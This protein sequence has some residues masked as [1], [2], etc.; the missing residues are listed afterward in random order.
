MN[1]IL[2]QNHYEF[3][4]ITQKASR[5]EIQKA[6]QGM[7]ETFGEKS[8]AFY[9]LFDPEDVSLIQ[10]R[11]E[12]AYT[13]LR[14]ENLRSA[15]DLT[16]P[17]STNPD[18]FEESSSP[19][20]DSRINTKFSNGKAGVLDSD[21]KAFLENVEE[22][23]TGKLLK[24]YREWKGIKLEDLERETR[25]KFTY[26]QFIEDDHISK[27]PNQVYLRSYLKQ[28]A[29]KMGIEPT[30]VVEGYLKRYRNE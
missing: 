8:I 10:L 27:L 11:I 29:E 1:R 5:D 20:A 30:R 24:R 21:L 23:C 17:S 9:S 18:S 4:E 22:L 7:K 15:Y 19:T 25:I 16:L 13:T 2:K 28:Y 3:F 12:N 14:D 26:L 6:Y